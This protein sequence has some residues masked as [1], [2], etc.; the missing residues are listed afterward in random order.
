MLSSFVMYIEDK[1]ARQGIDKES[2]YRTHAPKLERAGLLDLDGPADYAALVVGV[3]YADFTWD[4][5]VSLVQSRDMK[6]KCSAAGT[7]PLSVFG[8]PIVAQP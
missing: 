1:Q 7:V 3:E 5:K 8:P 4:N 2:C 6:I